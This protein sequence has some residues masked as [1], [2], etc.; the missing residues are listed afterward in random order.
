[1]KVVEMK[2][3][4]DNVI[5]S[6]IMIMN[7]IKLKSYESVMTGKTSHTEIDKIT[8]PTE[9]RIRLDYAMIENNISNRESEQV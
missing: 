1:M 5:E 3:S 9:K 6:M 7:R 2:I 4:D 8:H